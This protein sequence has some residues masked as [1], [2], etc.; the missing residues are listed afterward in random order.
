MFGLQNNDTD[1]VRLRVATP[2]DI[3]GL[4]ELVARSFR[5]LGA[6][7]YTAAQL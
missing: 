1:H 7:F 5:T 2:A 4:T 3:A 6:G